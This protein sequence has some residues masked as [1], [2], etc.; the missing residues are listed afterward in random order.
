[1]RS[2]LSRSS[3]QTNA[4]AGALV[5]GASAQVSPEKLGGILGKAAGALSPVNIT[6]TATGTATS[7]SS[8]QRQQMTRDIDK[9]A[10]SLGFGESDSAALTSDLASQVNSESAER[11]NRSLGEEQREQ[12]SETNPGSLRNRDLSAPTRPAANYRYQLGDGSERSG[13]RSS[14][15]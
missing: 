10:R 6:G 4:V 2:F 7:Q 14:W 9:M 3:S 11:F 5:L 12:V 8:D 15:Q 13:W 1:M